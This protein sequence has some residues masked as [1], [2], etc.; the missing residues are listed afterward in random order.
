MFGKTKVSF[1]SSLRATLMIV[2]IVMVWGGAVP[3]LRTDTA[4]AQSSVDVSLAGS[5]SVR[6]LTTN[7]TGGAADGLV[8]DD[9]SFEKGV[10]NLVTPM[11]E[12]FTLPSPGYNIKQVCV[13]LTTWEPTTAHYDIV[14]FDDNGTG[15]QPGSELARFGPYT[16]TGIAQGS[17]TWY[18]VPLN[19]SAAS[20]PVYIAVD[21]LDTSPN[22]ILVCADTSLST[23]KQTNY[24]FDPYSQLCGVSWCDAGGLFGVRAFG[25]RAEGTVRTTAVE[26]TS[27]PVPGCDVTVNLP[28]GSVVGKFVT[29][30]DVYWAPGE[31]TGGPIVLPQGQS[32]WV[33]GVDPTGQYYEILWSCDFLWVPVSSMGPNYDETWGGRPLPTTVIGGTAA[34][35]FSGSSAIMP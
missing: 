13:C 18:D 5:G 17:Y 3:S 4:Q 7:C 14:F 16:A 23:P 22:S 27:A 34:G 26:E 24:V 32:A 20:G 35:D 19:Y 25:I 30:A 6:A 33:L 2:L 21:L 15:G 1:K 31:I 10:G 12:L 28:E 29:N 11:A 9:G 8:H